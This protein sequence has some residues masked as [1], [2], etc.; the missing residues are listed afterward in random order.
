MGHRRSATLGA[1]KQTLPKASSARR[2][3]NRTDS[4]A[5]GMLVGLILLGVAVLLAAV[6]LWAGGGKTLHEAQGSGIIETIPDAL[7][8]TL[9][10]A[11][12]LVVCSYPLGYGLGARSPNTMAHDIVAL[13]DRL[14]KVA[15]ALAAS[16]AEVALLQA[17]DFASQRTHDVDQ[18]HYIAA[19]LGWGFAARVVTWECRYLVSLAWPWPWPVGRIRAGMGVISRYPLVQNTRQRLAASSSFPVLG[20]VFAPA[21]MIQM[22]DVQCGPR[23]LRLLHADLVVEPLATRQQ[24]ARELVDFVLQV[25]TPTSVLVGP[26]RPE[27]T[28]ADDDPAVTMI[29]DALHGRWREA[30][31][32]DRHAGA[33]CL[34]LGSGL[35][36]VETHLIP[37]DPAASGAY[38]L[39]TR[40]HWPL[41]MVVINGRNTHEPR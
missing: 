38:P 39:V 25:E 6:L 15:E 2:G 30:Q 5:E 16:G 24:Q 13:C 41:P 22:V 37:S 8:Q 32:D 12:T 4:G 10:P 26:W 17:V 3:G 28:E 35:R 29:V 1:C 7:E 40:L 18:L 21:Q 34:F 27:P 9:E 14:D 19:A 23:P 20:R 33:P 36:A 31:A 11:A